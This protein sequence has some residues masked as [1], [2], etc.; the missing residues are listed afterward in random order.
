MNKPS[1]DQVSTAIAW[2]RV[3]EGGGEEQAACEAVADYLKYLE[4]E[5]LIRNGA[6]QAGVKITVFRRKLRQIMEQR[7]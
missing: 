5:A 1:K 4:H 7:P 2:L 3:N 6:R